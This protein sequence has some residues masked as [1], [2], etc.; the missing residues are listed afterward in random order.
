[1]K[2]TSFFLLCSL[3]LVIYSFS[4][5]KPDKPSQT[6][7]GQKQ[8]RPAQTLSQTEMIQRGKYLVNAIGCH[9]CHSPKVMGPNGPKVDESRPL[10]GHPAGNPLPPV[11]KEALKNWILF[12]QELTAFVGPWGVSYAAN[13]TSD[14]TGIGNWTEK[15]FLTALRKGK[16][17]GLES[18]RMLLPPMP[19]DMYGKLNDTDL[20]SIFAYLK[21]TKPIK[22]KVPAPQAP[23]MVSEA[24]APSKTK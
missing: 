15:Q 3:I 18:N 23:E 8:N 19:W 12:N 7:G 16:Y 17:K 5:F 14:A 20:K 6:Q 2:K 11:N 10:S 4:S 24:P 13:L 9:D 22:N 1:M 21:T